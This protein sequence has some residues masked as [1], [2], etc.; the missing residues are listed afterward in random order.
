[1][2]LIL[3]TSVLNIQ[4]LSLDTISVFWL[5]I[6]NYAFQDFVNGYL[7]PDYKIRH[8]D[9]SFYNGGV[10]NVVNAKH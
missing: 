9:V 4:L 6:M 5:C 1:M 7:L 10:V 8:F 3:T 2:K